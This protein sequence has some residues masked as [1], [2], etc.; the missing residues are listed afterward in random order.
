MARYSSN[1]VKRIESL[2][3]DAISSLEQLRNDSYSLLVRPEVFYN[4][5]QEKVNYA[6]S[7]FEEFYGYAYE[8]YYK[9]IHN[10]YFL[11]V[12]ANRIAI[13]YNYMLDLC[14]ER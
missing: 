3:E 13:R 10:D 14:D 1:D 7:E 5:C 4:K 11:A 9:G 12:D 2:V 6:I 8:G